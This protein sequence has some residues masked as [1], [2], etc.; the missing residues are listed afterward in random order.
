MG[1]KSEKS[2]GNLSQNKR[3]ELKLLSDAILVKS[4]DKSNDPN[5]EFEIYNEIYN[6]LERIMKIESEIKVPFKSS[7]SEK[8]IENF[9]GWCVN[10]GAKFDKIELKDIP[11]YGLGLVSKE[12]LNEGEIFIEI[13]QNMIFSYS[14]IE[15]SIPNVLK[16]KIFSDC[17]LFENM[18]NVKLA[19]AL[20]IERM[21][22][23]SKFKPYFD[24]LPNKFSTVLYFT[25]TE[26]KELQGTSAF[27]SAIKQV[28]YISAQYAFLYKY[29][30]ITTNDSIM[31][32]LRDNFTYEFYRWA[33]SCVMTRQNIIPKDDGLN[34][35]ALIILWDMANHTNGDINTQYNN[36]THQIES[37]CM[38][39][40]KAGE[41]ITISYGNR[42]NEDFLVHNG[43][44]FKENTNTD[45]FV[46]LNLNKS[47]P[48]YENRVTLLKKIGLSDLQNYKIS[49]ELSNE[50]LGFIRVFNMNK[51][52]LDDWMKADE[53]FVKELLK[54]N[55]DLGNAF[56]I[57]IF[58]SL[59]IRVKILLKLYPTKLDDDIVLLKSGNLSKVKSMLVQYRLIEK[60]ILINVECSLQNKLKQLNSN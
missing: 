22:N 35:S 43:F 4:R 21:N 36:E 17:P 7:R 59:L 10:E 38:K 15:N 29:L 5:Q 45:L 3:N 52:Q 56:E 19:L 31:E 20:M 44:V 2:R 40:F 23:Q 37:F 33:V 39:N 13:P 14:K 1:K 6:L 50:V 57:K 16:Q 27:S 53:I 41:Q 32:E 60:N 9:I 47:D 54:P 55:L 48:L 12:S 26:M 46:K 18:S 24:V 25:P 30:M 28:K 11:D 51:E 8:A 34:E 42:S 49:P 58:Q